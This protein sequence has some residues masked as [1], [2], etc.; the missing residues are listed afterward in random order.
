[1][2]LFLIRLLISLYIY[3]FAG[4]MDKISIILLL[5]HLICVSFAI[6][7]FDQ[8]FGIH[9][10]HTVGSHFGQSLSLYSSFGETAVLVGAP[11]DT[12]PTAEI[13]ETG[14]TLR[15]RIDFSV[16]NISDCEPLDLKE[17][18]EDDFIENVGDFSGPIEE[19]KGMLMGSSL[20]S[21][22]VSGQIITCAPLYKIVTQE[23]INH[24]V[25]RC[26]VLDRL[27]STSEIVSPCEKV[28]SC[29][30]VFSSVI[31]SDNYILNCDQ[32][33]FEF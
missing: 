31:A 21:S 20:Y 3:I 5:V 7:I 22:S 25:G 33:M 17:I 13:T 32:S 4:D 6:D 19:K 29:F 15:C 9:Y 28:S 26:H 30:R 1:M 23:P 18:L 2:Y 14:S 12:I 10:T 16:S 27:N 11:L 24:P 8:R